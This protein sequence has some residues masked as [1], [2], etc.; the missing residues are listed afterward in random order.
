MHV[1]VCEYM[2]HVFRCLWRS[3]EGTGIPEAE[4]VQII[5]NLLMQML[6]T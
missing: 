2:P 1:C 3:E 4:I 6:R 5:V